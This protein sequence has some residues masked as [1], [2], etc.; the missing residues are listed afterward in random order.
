M[1]VTVHFALPAL[2]ALILTMVG[3]CLIRS[4][5]WDTDI[6]FEPVPAGGLPKDVE[7]AFRAVHPHGEILQVDSRILF[8]S[9][10]ESV[11]GG[12]TQAESPE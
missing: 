8:R 6:P 4:E 7:Q 11:T 10:S 1:R 9:A 5:C 2:A 3:G 12:K